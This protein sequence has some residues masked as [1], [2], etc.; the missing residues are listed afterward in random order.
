MRCLIIAFALLVAFANKSY[1]NGVGGVNN[2]DTGN[3][4]STLTADRFLEKMK[5]SEPYWTIQRS[6]YNIHKDQHETC[7]STKRKQE[8]EGNDYKFHQT[9]KFQGFEWFYETQPADY[10]V[11]F[12][13]T[14]AGLSINMEAILTDERVT[15]ELLP[16]RNYSLEYWDPDGKCFLLTLRLSQDVVDCELAA[17][18][19][20][21]VNGATFDNCQK[22]YQEKCPDRPKYSLFKEE[23]RVDSKSFHAKM[24]DT[25]LQY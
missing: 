25:Q 15:R 1:C 5:E 12:Q 8:T 18:N 17:W 11:T 21:A 6:F 20:N 23:C 7:I 4:A 9:Y 3:T 14:A 13:N 22:A 16:T 2:G 19:A 10:K 24:R